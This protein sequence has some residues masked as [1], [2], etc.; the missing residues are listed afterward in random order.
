METIYPFDQ[1]KARALLA[2]AGYKDGVDITWLVLNGSE[3]RLVAEAVQ[4]MVGE[5][6]IRVKLEV[7]D[8][9]QYQVFRIP[10][11]RGDVMMGRWGGR[12]DPLQTFQELTGTGGSVN[13]GKAAVPEIDSLIGE[14]RRLDPADPKRMVVLKRL[15]RLTTE[16]IGHIGLM[17]RPNVFV[18]KPGCISGMTP[19]LP[20]GSDRFN[21]VKLSASCK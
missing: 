13:A 12:A 19:Y 18:Y 17:T 4:A 3:Y 21:N 9:S 6:G 7:I 8:L 16:Q 14:A 10:P 20:A 5:V 15:A 1:A 2:E 11:K